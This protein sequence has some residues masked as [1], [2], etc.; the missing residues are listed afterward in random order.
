M[1]FINHWYF[2]SDLPPKS[3]PENM[4]KSR[5]FVKNWSFSLIDFDGSRPFDFR[6]NRILNAKKGP[7]GRSGPKRARAIE[8]PHQSFGSDSAIW[9]FRSIDLRPF[10]FRPFGNSATFFRPILVQSYSS[11]LLL[12]RNC[13]EKLTACVIDY[14]LK[15]VRDDFW[16][17]EFSSSGPHKKGH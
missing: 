3:K 17:R 6:P 8:G 15:C 12:E 5:F 9:P 16:L 13:I 14:T 11:I 1:N 10:K 4:Q 7:K 2:G